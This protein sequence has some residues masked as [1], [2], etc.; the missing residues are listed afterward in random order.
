MSVFDFQQSILK[1]YKTKTKFLLHVYNLVKLPHKST[2]FYKYVRNPPGGW[3]CL[4]I[5]HPMN[6]LI[7]A[8][9]FCDSLVPV[10]PHVQEALV[11]LVDPEW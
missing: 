9:R 11:P 7:T 6:S 4:D 1:F 10:N 5:N 8:T 3:V 2:K